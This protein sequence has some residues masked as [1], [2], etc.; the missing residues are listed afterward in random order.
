MSTDLD[1]LIRRVEE[2]RADPDDH[3][4]YENTYNDGW[5]DACYAV[6]QMLHGTRDGATVNDMRPD[7]R[8][9]QYVM[10]AAGIDGFVHVEKDRYAYASERSEAAGREEPNEMDELNGFRLLIDAAIAADAAG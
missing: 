4:D 10:H 7:T 6:I 8:R 5:L 2:I 9:L 1:D 3:K